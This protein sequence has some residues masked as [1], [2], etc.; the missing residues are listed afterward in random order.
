MPVRPP[1]S[2]M[3]IAATA[4][5]IGVAKVIR[6]RYIVNAQLNTFTPV[7]IDTSMVVTL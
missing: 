2:C 7:G 1:I 3:K 5:S 4:H 6:P